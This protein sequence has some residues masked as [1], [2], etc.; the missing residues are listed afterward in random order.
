ML[1][2]IYEAYF[3]P[4]YRYVYL[5]IGNKAA[6]PMTL[7]KIFL[8]RLIIRRRVSVSDNISALV[9]FLLYRQ[10]KSFGLEEK[11]EGYCFNR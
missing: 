3:K 6:N 8:S 2:I 5:R 10:K 11:K 4:L 9:Y 1:S 7:F